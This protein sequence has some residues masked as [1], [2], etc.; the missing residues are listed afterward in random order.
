MSH[1]TGRAIVS[2]ILIYL[3]FCWFH[4]FL[5]TERAAFHFAIDSNFSELIIFS[6]LFE[7]QKLFFCSLRPAG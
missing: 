7:A 5:L 1:R 3:Q 2:V 6:I 4:F